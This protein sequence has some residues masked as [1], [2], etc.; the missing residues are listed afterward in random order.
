VE[1]PSYAE[2]ARTYC[3]ETIEKIEDSHPDSDLDE[4]PWS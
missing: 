1:I 2:I 4:V 3:E